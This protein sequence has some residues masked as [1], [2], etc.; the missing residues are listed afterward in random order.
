MQPT[1]NYT[2]AVRQRGFNLVEA[3]I[4]LGVVGL[5]IGGIWTAASAARL[6]FQVSEIQKAVLQTCQTA[7]QLVPVSLVPT[8]FPNGW[9]RMNT[10][11]MQ[12]GIFPKSWKLTAIPAD[13]DVYLETEIGY[14]NTRMYDQAGDPPGSFEIGLS[15]PQAACIRLVRSLAGFNMSYFENGGRAAAPINSLSVWTCDSAAAD[16]SCSLQ[17]SQGAATLFQFGA[18]DIDAVVALCS[19]HSFV[20]VGCR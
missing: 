10:A 3:A 5:V 2:A 6:S 19:A 18:T 20:G 13:D 7:S 11:G 1:R 12:M 17:P 4:V 9:Q 14:A 8:T 16:A 15:M